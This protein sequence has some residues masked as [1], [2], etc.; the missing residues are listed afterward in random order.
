MKP[1]PFTYEAPTTLAE[2]V[3]VLGRY[4]DEAKVLA[5]GQSLVPVL[6]LRLARFEALV[7]LNRVEEL[8]Y[9]REDDGA[10]VIGAMTRQATVEADPLVRRAVPVLAEAT[11]L[12]GHFQIRN[13]GTLGGSIAHGDPAAE[14]PAVV[15]ALDGTVTVAGP[16]GH[17]QIAAADLY[18]GPMTSTLADEEILAA[19]SF[20]VW[21]PGSGFAVRE[22][23]RREGDFATAGTVVG[24]TVADGK[25]SRAAISL[26]G[27]GPVPLR[28]R[29]AEAQLVGAQVSGDG[30]TGLDLTEVGQAAVAGIDPPSDVHA[31][32]RYRARVAS[33]LVARALESALQEANR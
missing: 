8:A 19:V 29:A 15:T 22:M 31:S 6:A 18:D 32:G 4:G 16:N 21:G 17:R 26:F 9:V 24:V 3:D 20:P 25:I 33:R 5:G 28:A 30:A 12:I 2:A 11:R 10:V 13:R 23:A 7:D 27:M 1:A 14:Y